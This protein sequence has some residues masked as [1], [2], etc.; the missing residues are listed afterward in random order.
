MVLPKGKRIFQLGIFECLADAAGIPEMR[1]C[2]QGKPFQIFY[3]L[4]LMAEQEYL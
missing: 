1:V 3:R 4:L 2:P